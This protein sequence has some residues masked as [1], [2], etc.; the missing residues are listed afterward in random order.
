MFTGSLK[1]NGPELLLQVRE[2]LNNVNELVTGIQG[3]TQSLSK[4]QNS[5]GTIGKL[6][7]DTEV[8][9]NVLE[10]VE[11]VRDLSVKLEPLVNDLRSFADV[12]A[13]DPGMIGVRGALDRRPGKTGYKGTAGRDGG[14]IR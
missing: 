9:D 11:N 5:E 12:L 8:Y 3:F 7:N 6:L 13:R 4:L 10:T 1:E 2:S 14:L